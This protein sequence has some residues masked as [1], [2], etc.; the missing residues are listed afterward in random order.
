MVTL[1]Q[2]LSI[3][4][5]TI[6][7]IFLLLLLTSAVHMLSLHYPLCIVNCSTIKHFEGRFSLISFFPSHSNIVFESCRRMWNTGFNVCACTVWTVGTYGTASSIWSTAY[8]SFLQQLAVNAYPVGQSCGSLHLGGGLLWPVG[9]CGYEVCTH[10]IYEGLKAVVCDDASNAF[11]GP[12]PC[13]R[14]CNKK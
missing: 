11:L 2:P 12:I 14:K 9:W 13:G 8:Y 10:S 3:K 6:Y 7:S 5:W 1:L 4:L